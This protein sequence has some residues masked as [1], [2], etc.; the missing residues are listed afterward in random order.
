MILFLNKSEP[1]TWLMLYRKKNPCKMQQE[2]TFYK[3]NARCVASSPHI[4]TTK[5]V[6]FNYYHIS[7][8]TRHYETF[9]S[10]ILLY[11]VFCFRECLCLP[12]FKNFSLK[13]VFNEDILR[14]AI[15]LGTVNQLSTNSQQQRHCPFQSCCRLSHYRITTSKQIWFR[16]GIIN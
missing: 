6:Q 16:L 14:P 2:I 4:Y 7:H 9:T 1:S 10:M 5:Q 11:V 8:F 12:K 3:W 15:K 13:F